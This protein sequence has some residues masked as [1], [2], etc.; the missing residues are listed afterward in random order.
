MNQQEQTSNNVTI[1]PEGGRTGQRRVNFSTDED[2]RMC[3]AWVATSE[4][5]V[6]GNNQKLDKFW[7]NVLAHFMESYKL[8]NKV[9][10]AHR[11]A[12]SLENR[13]SNSIK[14][15]T[16]K[17]CGYLSK[18]LMLNQSGKNDNDK[19]KAFFLKVIIHIF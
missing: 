1:V 19:V 17:F 18:I 12:R 11:D 15:A 13:Y 4:N 3:K 6:T 8:E 14:T 9:Q 16:G 2:T 5:P 10:D 7:D